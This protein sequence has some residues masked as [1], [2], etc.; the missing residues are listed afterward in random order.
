MISE[1]GLRYERLRGIPHLREP[2]NSVRKKTGD[3]RVFKPV[4]IPKKCIRCK[5]CWLFCPENAIKWTKGHPAWDYSMCKGCMICYEVCP[6]K[7]IK[8]VR[9]RQ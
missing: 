4:W 7:A 6:A 1:S 8:T 5:R 9:D 3:W 2:G